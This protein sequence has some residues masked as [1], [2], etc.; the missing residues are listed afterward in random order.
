VAKVPLPAPTT[1]ERLFFL[2]RKRGASDT[3]NEPAIAFRAP[4]YPRSAFREGLVNRLELFNVLTSVSNVARGIGLTGIVQAFSFFHISHA[5]LRKSV[6]R[7]KEC[8]ELLA[9]LLAPNEIE[10]LRLEIRF[11]TVLVESVEETIAAVLGRTVSEAF[12]YHFYAYPE[13]SR[14]DI[15]SHLNELSLA[16]DGS[17]GVGGLF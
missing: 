6:I 11:N 8:G 7:T 3:G 1:T 5:L 12:C 14:T 15:P 17:F 10:V 16:L 4:E 13:I 2:E 9:D